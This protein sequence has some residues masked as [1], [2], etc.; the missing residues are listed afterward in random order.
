MERQVSASS[1]LLM[2]S[3]CLDHTLSYTYYCSLFFKTGCG[4][5]SR[6]PCF[7]LRAKP[8]EPT[9]AAPEV[10][11]IVSQPRRIAAKALAERVRSCEPD[12]APKIALR[13]GHGIKEHETSKTR[14]WFVTTGYVVRLLANH[15]SWFNSH[16]HLIIDEVHE[17]S[18]DT[19]ILC[20]LCR[21]LL[22]SHPTIR[23]VLM[24]ATMA[25]E[26]Y[27]QYFGTPE[28]PIH[29]GARRFPIKEF[30]VEDLS[31]QLSLSAKGAKNARDIYNECEKSKC[32]SAPAASNMEKL[33]FV[34]SQITASVTSDRHYCHGSSVLIFVPG[35]SDIE[36]IIEL[37]ENL[38]VKGCTFICLPIHSD[39]PFEEQ[40]AAFEPPGEGEVKVII[41]TNAA[42][43]SLTLPDV[44]H[45]ICLG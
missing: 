6:V 14:A 26:L 16:T 25:A 11:M 21:R 43:S 10:K 19:D 38:N 3:T 35:M 22:Q 30:F 7:L 28:P 15:P 41:A 45:V 37:I 36:A 40:M 24:S 31:S 29:V 4:K 42:E 2:V 20:L 33:Y 39:V 13:M 18:I 9:S 1:S 23:L 5:S 8:P 27:S 44:D 12:I 34:A 17:R 32:S